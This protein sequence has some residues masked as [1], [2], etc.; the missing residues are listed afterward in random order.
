LCGSQNA[1]IGK[2][3]ARL[4]AVSLG[5]VII[6]TNKLQEDEIVDIGVDGSLI[7]HYPGSEEY[8]REAFKEIGGI[9][10]G[11]K[12]IRIG[13]AKDG[14]GLEAALVALVAHNANQ[15]L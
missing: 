15:P 1:A 3:A 4:V 10:K 13:L 2:R 5:S 12:R 11:E 7:E 8:I 6:S 14:S 9:G